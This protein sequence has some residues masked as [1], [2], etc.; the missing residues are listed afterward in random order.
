MMQGYFHEL[1]DHL[2]TLLR[3]DEVYLAAYSAE[4]SDFVRFNHGRIGQAMHVTQQY[5]S[6][7]LINGRRHLEGSLTLSGDAELDRARLSAL[8]VSLRERL[9]FL[10]EDPYLLYATEVRS[11]EREGE[12]RLPD[13]REAVGDVLRAA[14]GLDMVGIYGGGGIFNGFANSLGQRNWFSTF[15]HNLDWSLYHA[16]DKAVKTGYAGFEWQA[17]VLERKMADAREQLGHLATSPRTIDPGAYRV[18]LSPVALDDI[19]QMLTWGG[20]GLKDHRTRQTP[21]IRMI[22]GEAR[23]REDVTLSE[24]TLEGVAAEFQTEGYIKPPR[25][26]LIDGGRF[27]ACLASPRS[28][29]EYGVATNGA[30]E[31]ESPES[32]DLAAGTIPRDDVLGELGT[33]LYVNNLHYL[34]FSDRTACRMTGMTRFATFWVEKGRI[35]AP[36][37]VMRFDESVYRVL[38]ENLIGLTRERDFLLDPMTYGGRST[39]SSRLPGALIEEFTFTL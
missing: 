8:M 21:L 10:P 1:C 27:G 36:V 19:V 15:S 24:N 30:A 37:N 28:A 11:T 3:G 2:A 31:S 26:T 7:H 34:N 9:G 23:L 33:G 12:D 35:V 14:C 4:D 5:M 39:G 29:Q 18:Y 32:L 6:L 16:A 20:F 22:D 25:V 13:P 17:P 38:G